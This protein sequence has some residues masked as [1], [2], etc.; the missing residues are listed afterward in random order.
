MLIRMRNVGVRMAYLASCAAIMCAAAQA[1]DASLP[2]P[3]T[4]P[5]P[6]IAPTMLKAGI[7][8]SETVQPLEPQFMPGKEF[9]PNAVALG[10][11][12]DDWICIPPWLAGTFYVDRSLVV[13]FVDYR[14][15]THLAPNKLESIYRT[16]HYGH[17]I[18]TKGRVWHLNRCPYRNSIKTEGNIQY[19]LIRQSKF[20]H[21]GNDSVLETATG[22]AIVV[23]KE[24][25]TI[26]RSTTIETYGKFQPDKDC[27][28]KTTSIKGFNFAGMP[29]DQILRVEKAYML[30]P[31]QT[32]V[33]TY[34]SFNKFMQQRA[35]RQ[36]MQNQQTQN[37]QTKNQQVQDQQ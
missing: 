4:L 16:F 17:Q 30:Q 10:E 28:R 7:Q 15:R 2:V 37:Q 5:S 9:N 8:H 26:V 25:G 34:D 6:S 13:D 20:L 1:Q 22:P 32:D 23:S 3:P 12:V 31:F 33:Q 11:P 19:N 27:I 35:L 14:T 18:D 24:T 36:Q 29:E 21:S